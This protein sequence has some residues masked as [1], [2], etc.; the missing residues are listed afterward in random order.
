MSQEVAAVLEGLPV[1]T[2]RPPKASDAALRWFELGLVLL[3]AFGSGVLGSIH[4]LVGA[5]VQSATV[6][7]FRWI[8]AGLTDIAALLL[9]GYVLRRRNLR[10]RDLGLNWR[11]G[12]LWRGP[13][14]ALGAYIAYYATLPIFMWIQRLIVH[15][16]PAGLTARQSFGHATLAMFAAF[17]L[18][19][20]FE[21]LIVRAY[22][23]TEVRELTGSRTLAV[24]LSVTLQTS[25]HLYYGWAIASSMGT[26][27]LL[28]SIYYERTRRA[29]PIVIAHEVLDLLGLIALR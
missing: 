6:T 19:P 11:W 17:L 5:P 28:F 27:F 14:L 20:W 24:A 16:V 22:L 25:Y 23:M 3:I 21:E 1:E 15:G 12:H 9:L 26:G 4:V 18:N 13:A 10:I 2:L 29:V 7:Y 8:S